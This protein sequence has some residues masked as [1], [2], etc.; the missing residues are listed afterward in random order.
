MPTDRL[1]RVEHEINRSHN[2]HANCMEKDASVVGRREV[3]GSVTWFCLGGG[4]ALDL[5]FISLKYIFAL[6]DH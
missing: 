2:K 3:T 4:E 1:V 6:T 5:K